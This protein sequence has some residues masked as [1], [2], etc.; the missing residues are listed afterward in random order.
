MN[1]IIYV[2]KPKGFTS[3]DVCNKLK[4]V[5]NVKKIG[6]TGTLDPNATGVLVI[7][8]NKAVKCNQF[9]LNSNKEYIAE[10]QLGIK[11]TTKDIWGDVMA[12]EPY[13]IPANHEIE[14]VLKSF[15]G[16]QTQIPPMTS[17]IKVNGKKLYELQRANI[18]IE[19]PKREIEIM[20]I[21]LLEVNDSIKFRVLVSKGTYIR[22][23][24]EDIAA[25]LGSLGCMKSLIRTKVNNVT[26]KD[27]FTLEDI[28]NGNYT[29]H[30]IYDI[31]KDE[32]YMHETDDVDHIKQGKRI[33]VNS[34]EDVIM[35]T[36]NHEV[37]AAY[38]RVD[39]YTYKSKRGLF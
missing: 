21:E 38:Q 2:N 37:L 14:A 18:E 28:I 36:H 10:L 8:L 17:A 34:N 32:Y 11:T 15:L 3:F 20:D 6:H 26:L 4:R 35:V 1:G 27:C 33:R 23:L 31:L 19:P 13:Q 12:E 29:L 16:K 24:C 25:K 30:S 7:M 5:L 22:S 9:L 39:E